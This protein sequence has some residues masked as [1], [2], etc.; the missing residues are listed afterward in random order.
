VKI[1]FHDLSFTITV[2]F[3]GFSA[4]SLQDRMNDLQAKLLR[5]I[6]E[7]RIK[8]V[9]S[10]KYEKIEARIIAAT[11]RD[12]YNSIKKGEFREDLFYRLNVIL[13]EIPPLREHKED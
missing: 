9:G 3:G 11:N 4:E 12:I 2:V 1:Y 5:A 6:Q 7:M 8:P 13:I 10:N